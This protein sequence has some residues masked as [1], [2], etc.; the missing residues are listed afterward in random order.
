MFIGFWCPHNYDVILSRRQ[1]P[2]FMVLT[3][4]LL[5]TYAANVE[6]DAAVKHLKRKHQLSHG[7]QPVTLLQYSF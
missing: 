3:S 4:T 7:D 2:V 5:M 1:N 6:G